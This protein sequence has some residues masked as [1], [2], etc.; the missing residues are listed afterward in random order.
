MDDAARWAQAERLAQ[1]QIDGTWRKRR[2]RQ[3]LLVFLPILLVGVVAGVLIALLGP[4]HHRPAHHT[5]PPLW[6]EITS[7]ALILIGAGVEFLA[8]RRM[9]KSGQLTRNWH[10]PLMALSFRQRRGVFKQVR[11]KQPADLAHL[12]VL[13]AVATTMQTAYRSGRYGVIAGVAIIAV[14]Q[15]VQRFSV[16]QVGYLLVLVALFLAGGVGL[17]RNSRAAA[18][19][20]QSH[21]EPA[22]V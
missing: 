10:S 4:H 2:R 14:G 7:F 12:T 21:P 1:G 15:A 3:Y 13:R 8:V 19:F 16:F 22:S 9:R 6:R 18:D 20:L 5:D 11:G 17:R